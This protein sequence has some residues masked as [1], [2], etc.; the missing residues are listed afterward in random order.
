M[1]EPDYNPMPL[2]AKILVAVCILPALDLPWLWAGNPETDTAKTLLW[3]YPAFTLLAGVCAW[4]AWRRSRELSF[5][6]LFLLILSHIA[7][8]LLCCPPQ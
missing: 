3:L 6:L 7:M 1:T 8:W 5:I 4:L 2:W